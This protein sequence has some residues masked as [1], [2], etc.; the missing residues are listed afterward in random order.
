MKTL[1]LHGK[2]AEEAKI[3]V[4]DFLL[5]CEPPLRVITGNSPMMKNL[6]EGQLFEDQ[7]WQYEN[8]YNL[9]SMIILKRS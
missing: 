3:L 5:C 6:V 9:G 7:K 2:T 1:D 4:E 8:D